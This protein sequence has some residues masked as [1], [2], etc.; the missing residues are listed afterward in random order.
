MVLML[1]P[2]QTMRIG[3]RAD[4]GRLFNITRYGSRISAR[5]LLD[6][7]ATAPRIPTAVTKKK[8]TRVSRMVTP[9]CKKML[10]SSTMEKKQRTMRDGELKIKALITPVLAQAS[11][12]T[13]TERKRKSRARTTIWR[14]RSCLA[15]NS[16]WARVS[17][18]FMRHLQIT[19][20]VPILSESSTPH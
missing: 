4:L 8:L 5:L 17:C 15:T 7:R 14:R 9:V 11:Q 20:I 2:S 19:G 16:C 6:Q 1:L 12:R 13:R 10:P 3:A 18:V